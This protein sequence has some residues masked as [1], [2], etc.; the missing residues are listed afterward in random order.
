MIIKSDVDSLLLVVWFIIIA[1][2]FEVL[3]SIS[4]IA[5][6]LIESIALRWMFISHIKANVF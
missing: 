2:M 4:E 1:L 6:V 5:Q 3:E